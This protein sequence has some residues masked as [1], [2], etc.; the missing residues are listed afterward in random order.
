MLTALRISWNIPK[1][2]NADQRQ[3]A[4]DALIHIGRPV[5]VPLF[6]ARREAYNRGNAQDFMRAVSTIFAA[7]KAGDQLAMMLADCRDDISRRLLC[8]ELGDLGDT[9]G[10]EPLIAALNDSCPEVRSSAVKALQQL[11]DIRAVQPLINALN[12]EFWGIRGNAA[13]A[14]ERLNDVRA[15]EP[16]IKTLALYAMQ[17]VAG[18]DL[19][20]RD[21]GYQIAH[22]LGA[23]GD[24]RAIEPLLARLKDSAGDGAFC[25]EV[26]RALGKLRARQVLP[27]CIDM[28]KDKT[29]CKAA[30]EALGNLGDASA[31][32]PLVAELQIARDE[33]LFFPKW[34]TMGTGI[35][36]HALV[37]LDAGHTLDTLVDALGSANSSFVTSVIVEMRN[38][39]N[40]GTLPLEPLLAALA[41]KDNRV[42][43][44]I[45]TVLKEVKDP[46]IA[47]ALEKQR[48]DAGK[49]RKK[50]TFA[51]T[52]ALLSEGISYSFALSILGPP[53]Q[54]IGGGEVMGGFGKVAASARSM[55]AI[56]GMVFVEWKREEGSYRA[57]FTDGVL[58]ELDAWPAEA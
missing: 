30:A 25:G 53:S 52:R 9:S 56:G 4:I 3:A 24:P 44:G 27:L 6:K 43:E 40:A 38:L 14:L 47:S 22:A 23:L 36:V 17:T 10:V 54:T 55:S 46:R 5:V 8:E 2:W 13:K 48:A 42:C 12:D 16:L 18:C 58:T 57:T 50:T 19:R 33:P 15:V 11:G 34:G 31:V 49:I 20:Q 51:E 1:L 28:L 37:Q 35:L 41:G 7:V 39:A 21:A 32:D 45:A 29:T 26:V